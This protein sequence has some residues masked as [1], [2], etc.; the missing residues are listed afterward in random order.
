METFKRCAWCNYQGDGYI[1]GGSET[2]EMVTKAA[3]NGNNVNGGSIGTT[4]TE[5]MVRGW[6]QLWN[7]GTM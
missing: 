6:I 2:A 7:I 5:I 4:E 1:S 3:Q